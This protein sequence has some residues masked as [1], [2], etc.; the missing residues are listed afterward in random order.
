MEGQGHRDL[1]WELHRRLGECYEAD[2]RRG[3]PLLGH[4]LPPSPR[5]SKPR[6]ARS[7]DGSHEDDSD[8]ASIGPDYRR[9]PDERGSQS[10]PQRVES[11]AA[12]SMSASSL[13]A[14][15]V[16]LECWLHRAKTCNSR[17]GTATAATKSFGLAPADDAPSAVPRSAAPHRVLGA[18]K[19]VP[20]MWM[21]KWSSCVLSPT[22]HFRNFWDLLGILLLI[23][24][25]IALPLQFVSPA[26]YDELPA[27]KVIATMEV[28]FW[29]TDI[30]LS[31]CTGYLDKGNLILNRKDIA[32]QYLK[33]WFLPDL[34]VTL[35]DLVITFFSDSEADRASTRILRLL[36]L[37]RVVRLGKLTRFASF[38]RDKFESEVAYTQFTLLLL[39]IG[40]IL[41]E[42]FIACGWF[43]IGSLDLGGR[44]TWVEAS[45]AENSSFTLQY[46]HSLRW[47][48]SQ[49]G[50]GGTNI[51]AT[52]EAEG[53]YSAGVA[54]VS[55]IIF[56]TIMGSMTSLVSTLQSKRME[57]TQQ[58]GLL[59]R[60][61]RTSQVHDGLSQRVTRFLHY[62]YHERMANSDDPYILD[63]LSK[64]LQAEL[65]LARYSSQLMRMVFFADVLGNGLSL[66]EGKSLQT[67]A[68]QAIS[69][70]SLAEDDV[71]F[72]AGHAACS[73]YMVTS[74]SMRYL[75]GGFEKDA[76]N[77]LWISEMCLWTSWHH[78]GDLVCHSF[79]KLVAIH[80]EDFC[81]IISASVPLQVQAHEYAAVYVEKMNSAASVDDLRIREVQN[82]G[83]RASLISLPGLKGGLHW[84]AFPW[85]KT[86]TPVP[87][88]PTP[89]AKTA[90]VQPQLLS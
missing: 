14:L 54:L 37:F 55:L 26:L 28:F 36:R 6:L 43:G 35:I 77:D 81:R 83:R 61:L 17:G 63:F 85:G 29:S 65:Q 67:L 24:D 34:V 69:L 87:K 16:P 68:S 1:F 4:S 57:Q 21:R 75:Q 3:K 56:S 18:A 39:I 76:S 42:H 23:C 20:G 45:G 50:I 79:C 48:F 19:T 64:S 78:V 84:F 53:I 80:S 7:N 5:L 49:L 46:T 40:M 58:F 60:F 51:E 13:G 44:M 62:T 47:A 27:L 86:P 59:R 31:F 74:G 82:S 89:V 41:L 9:S 12:A 11:S 30:A 2:V 22:G 52:N 38:L 88:T 70:H 73:A 15:A 71:V 10:A 8:F 66:Q 32:L 33:S 90:Q 25:A 72:C